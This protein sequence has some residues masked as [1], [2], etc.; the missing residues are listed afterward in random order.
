MT[1]LHRSYKSSLFYS[2]SHK[3]SPH[4][5]NMDTS[6][7]QLKNEDLISSW[8]DHEILPGRSISSTVTR[9]IDQAD[10]VSF[11]ISQDFLAS[12]ECIK[13]WNR[14]K[15]RARGNDRLFRIPIILEDCAWLDFLGDD[16]IKALPNDGTPV[17]RFGNSRTLPGIKYM[18]A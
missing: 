2:Y 15:S 8:S 17:T 10:I 7:A 13:E 12:E 5:E 1:E 4:K 11:L 6:L 3:N 18:K 9:K 14:I 16:D